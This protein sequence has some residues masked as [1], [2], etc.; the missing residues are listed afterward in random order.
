MT[1]LGGRLKRRSLIGLRHSAVVKGRTLGVLF[2]AGGTLALIVVLVPHGARMNELAVLSLALAAGVVGSVFWLVGP[3][4]SDR[5]LHVTLAFGTAE[6][7]L[8]VYFAHGGGPSTAFAFLFTWVGLYAALF[9]KPRQAR[10]HLMLCGVAFAAVL[11]ANSETGGAAEWVLAI[12]TTTIVVV[13]VGAIM[14]E[15]H[16]AQVSVV[17]K[18]RHSALSEMA[19]LIGHELRN[20]LA[21]AIN[22]LYIHRMDVARRLEHTELVSVTRAEA[23][24]NRAAQLS[25]DLISYMR[26][27]ELE[28]EEIAVDVLVREVL[29]EAP[30]PPGVEVVLG[31]ANAVVADR[32]VLVTVLANLLSNSY[33]AMKAGGTIRVSSVGTTEGATIRVEDNGPGFDRESLGRAFDAFFTTKDDGTGLGLA[34]VQRL[35]ERLDGTVVVENAPTG[36]ARVVIWLPGAQ[37]QN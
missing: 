9:F 23:Q 7:A 16:E 19:T 15:L 5:T 1:E 3:R 24:I 17:R 13:V 21:A 11:A 35:V 33:Q 4:F 12:G 10:A 29:S 14:T 31:S 2:L 25:E 26:D 20:P 32:N 36:G 37:V 34:V 18:E 27:S 22:D 8:A 28:P 6:I 30:P